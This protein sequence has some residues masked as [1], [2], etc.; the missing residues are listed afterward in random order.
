MLNIMICEDENIIRRRIEASLN[1][2]SI[3]NDIDIE[4]CLSTGDPFDIYNYATN[5]N[6]DV[7]LLDIDLKNDTMDGIKLGTELRKLDKNIIIVFISSRL[8]KIFEC[9][10]CNPFDF[11][12]KPSI[13]P[14]LEETILRIVENKLYAPH[15][16]FVKIKNRIINLDEIIYIEKQLTKS[17]FYLTSN[18][19]EIYV[20]F[21]QLADCLADNFLQINKSYIINTNYITDINT[22]KKEIRLKNSNVLNYSKKYILDIG[23]IL[24]GRNN[25]NINN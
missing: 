5:H 21:L 22:V 16:N 25:Q 11:I 12:P 17:V 10:T 15:G 18:T 13:N 19:T 3:K 2:I 20:S 6:C 7:L 24:N 8:E 9:F 14:H 4:V 23:R 1:E